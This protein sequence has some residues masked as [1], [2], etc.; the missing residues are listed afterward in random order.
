MKWVTLF[1]AVCITL[2]TSTIIQA[3]QEDYEKYHYAI[4]E[5]NIQKIEQLI[6][7]GININAKSIHNG[8]TPLTL[9]ASHGISEII[10]LL[11][12]N[13]AQNTPD[14][15]GTT[16]LM[17]AVTS[18]SAKAVELLLEKESNINAKNSAGVTALMY[19]VDISSYTAGPRSPYIINLLISAGAN[20]NAISNNKK[21]A[22]DK[23][24]Q[25]YNAMAID[26]LQKAGGKTAQELE[27]EQSKK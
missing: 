3:S 8:M 17:Y 19:A 15:G 6:R 11:L 23:A 2:M 22:L 7:A 14:T 21:T 9:A 5:S 13:G 26:L 24:K 20:V 16:P 10:Q 12:K 25:R 18:N 4:N 27:E 1:K